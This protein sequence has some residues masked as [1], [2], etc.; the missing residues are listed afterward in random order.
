[1]ASVVGLLEV[2]ELAARERVEGLREEADRVL[3]E[4]AEAETDWQ[5]W[6]IAR[7]RVGEV[8]S[9]PSG[10]DVV[11]SAVEESSAPEAVPVPEAPEGVPVSPA[12]RAGSVVPVWR[13]ALSAAVLAVDYQRILALLAERR[14]GGD[15]VMTCQSRVRMPG[16]WPRPV[17]TA[18]RR[19]RRSA[20]DHGRRPRG[21]GRAAGRAVRPTA[22]S[23]PSGARRRRRGPT[24]GSPRAPPAT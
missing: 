7:Q 10:T 12:A 2:R 19:W 6:V 15:G 21:P 13:P 11:G 23:R 20:P 16:R 4:L 17:P 5:E 18:S 22:P 1:M 9:A 24:R 3:A 14:G 8:L